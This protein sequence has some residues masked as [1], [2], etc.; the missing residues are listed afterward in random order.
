[1]KPLS[2]LPPLPIVL[3][4]SDSSPESDAVLMQHWFDAP[5]EFL[6]QVNSTLATGLI[7]FDG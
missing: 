3:L 5:I 2:L 1:M 7:K 6:L 4:A